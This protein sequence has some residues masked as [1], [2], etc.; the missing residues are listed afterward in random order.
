MDDGRDYF[1]TRRNDRTYVST[2]FQDYSGRNM[3]IV[4]KVIDGAPEGLISV[5]RGDEIVVRRTT[6]GRQ[7]I[8][9]TIF[10]DDRGIRTLTIQKYNAKS[11]P[12][13]HEYFSF[14]GDEIS[15]LLEFIVALKRLNF[16]DDQR[17]HISDE[18]LREFVLNEEQALRLFREHE[19]LFRSLAQNETLTRDIVAVGYR[20]AQLERFERLLN[21]AAFFEA[22][23]LAAGVKP[24][25][26]WQSFFEANT[27]IFGYGLSY[28]F[29]TRLD[30][31][32]LEQ[33][34]QGYDVSGPGRRVDALMK[35]QAL[36][37]AVC[38]VEIKR[39]DTPLL[40]AA[41]YRTDAWAPHAELSGAVAQVQASV[42]GALEELGRKIELRDE[43]GEPTGEKLFNIQ[44]RAFL[45]AGSHA[46]FQSELGINEPKYKSFELY[47]RNV[48]LP[49]ILTFDELLYRARFIVEHSEGT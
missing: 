32:K 47:R 7:E 22:E 46:Q 42:Q 9:A 35:T 15:T 1:F 24:E 44:P 27:W 38:F 31:R 13:G 34:T 45:I 49:E 33:I 39:H 36:I 3:R 25:G 4:N 48:R 37:N 43:V 10:E 8:K 5:A 12:S 19:S 16:R 18:A 17:F 6:K 30:G 11:G 20:R 21:D 40:A 26:L 14:V 28:Q 41:Q 23:R 2:R 29:L